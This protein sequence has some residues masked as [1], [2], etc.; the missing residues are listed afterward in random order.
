MSQSASS[1][2]GDPAAAGAVGWVSVHVYYHDPPD[3]L[4][5]V[6][7]GGLV[8][9]LAAL[10][11][12]RS[13]FFLRHWQGGPHVRLR[14]WPAGSG[15]VASVRHAVSED[16][17]GFLRTH[18]SSMD[19]PA[20]VYA[21]GAAALAA[22]EPGS[23]G[24]EPLAPNNSLRFAD[25]DP[26]AGG[27][28]STPERF[29][30]ASSRAVL[31]LLDRPMSPTRRTRLGLAHLVTA[32]TALA[33]T[34]EG[35]TVEGGRRLLAGSY[36][37]WGAGLLGDRRAAVEPELARLAGAARLRLRPVLSRL[38][39]SRATGAWAECLRTLVA[40]APTMDAVASV[41]PADARIW[42]WLHTHC[43]R[44]GLTL[45]DEAHL[46]YLLSDCARELD[47]MGAHR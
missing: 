6:G 41:G 15:D 22:V 33:G 10:G 24:P 35:G 20:D 12:L 42:Y 37:A 29:A 31:A 26:A 23:D 5:R 25:Y 32:A 9:R 11:A 47:P 34:V 44:L 1:T 36:E 43:N 40:A 16:L 18:P 45:L 39:A 4:L 30:H 14:L 3:E 13:W 2:C 21:A 19:L 46:H 8:R 27:P 7:V 17:G 38:L 28:W